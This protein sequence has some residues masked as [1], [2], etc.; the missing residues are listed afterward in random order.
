MSF[1]IPV[2][3]LATPSFAADQQGERKGSS[4]SIRW[5]NDTFGGTDAN[6]TNGFSLALTQHGKGPIGG[7]WHLF[8]DPEGRKFT[9]YD[10]GQL[11]FN[12][13][14]TS[15]Q[16]PDP[17]DRP[18]AGLL[19]LGLTTYLQHDESLHGLKLFIG[20]VGPA[21]LGEAIQKTT[22]RVFLYN[23]PQGWDSQLKNEPVVNL[24]YEYRHRYTLTP[25]DAAVGVELIPM[26]SAMLGNF[27]IQAQ[28]GTQFRI[29]YHLP[30]DFGTTLLRGIGYLPFPQSDATHHS[31][32]IYAF[33]G[34][35]ASIVARNLTLDGNTFANS[36]S[37]DKRLFVPALEVGASLWSRRLQASFSYVMMGKEFYGQQVREDYGSILLS[38]FFR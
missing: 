17:N 23:M 18:Y 13:D 31:W 19:Y 3:A 12:P 11:V 22:H 36:R 28:A 14:D 9:T 35:S 2:C 1:I 26:G 25:R 15:R 34:G 6:Y 38:Y 7:A 37:V 20:V 10:L 29:G 33:A 32:G 24:L 5:E 16:V 21:S 30:D 27:L 8:G 4:F